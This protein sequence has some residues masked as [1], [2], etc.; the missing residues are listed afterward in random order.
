MI[1]SK[2]EKLFRDSVHGYIS[3]PNNYCYHFVDT[4]EF[5]RLRRI[6]QTSIRVLFPSARHDRFIHS[7]GVFHL[8]R[9]AIA[10]IEKNSQDI[11]GELEGNEWAEIKN[12]F[13]IACLLH[14]IGHT[15][16]SHTFQKYLDIPACLDEKLS[17]LIGESDKEFAEDIQLNSSKEH[18][19][20]SGII[21]LKRFAKTIVSDFNASPSLAARMV[22]G[23]RYS[24]ASSLRNKIA[25]CLI[26]LLNGRTIDVD[27]LDYINRDAWASGYNT[28]SIDTMR[29]LASISIKSKDKT[30]K[31]LELVFHKS[32]LSQIISVL[33]AKNSQSYWFLTHHKVV[34]DQYLLRKSIEELAK[35]LFGEQE[36][37]LGRLF[38]VENFLEP[39]AIGDHKVYLPT[40]DDIVFMLKS[41]VDSI[42]YAKEFLYRQHRLKPLWKTFA[43]FHSLFCGP[44]KLLEEDIEENGRLHRLVNSE[45]VLKY[46]KKNISQ[47]IKQVDYLVRDVTPKF[48]L[49]FGQNVFIDLGDEIICY[50]NLGLPFQVN[51]KPKSFFLIFVRDDLLKEKEAIVNFLIERAKG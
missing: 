3:I 4:P 13:Q 33:D 5:Q 2:Q 18:E 50:D 1:S 43:E 20:A 51:K 49:I 23:L 16:F 47:S 41:N 10:Q 14:D 34:Y 42:C 30:N 32:A 17:K 6:E 39:T 38:N 24:N 22:I 45:R 21:I 44:D 7:I 11:L 31:N 25:N 28:G 15:P 46:M 19:R 48:S 9:L 29:L 36:K 8:G 26:N 37:G 35:L 40:D 27:R 12:T